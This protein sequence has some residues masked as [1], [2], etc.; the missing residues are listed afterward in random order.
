MKYQFLAALLFI[1]ELPALGQTTTGARLDFQFSRIVLTNGDTLTGP[2]AMRYKTDVLYLAQPDGTVRNLYPSMVAAFA[3]QGERFATGQGRY[4]ATP[5]ADPTVLRLFRTLPWSAEHPW[6]RPEPYFFEQLVEGPVLL[7]RR[8]LLVPRQ[9]A[10]VKPE[11]V[12]SGGPN[13]GQ[14][15]AS[16]KLPIM[17]IV[18][19]QFRTLNELQ[20]VFYLA[21][22]TGE[23]RSLHNPKKDLLAAF[24]EQAQ[25]LQ[26]YARAQGLGFTEAHELSS[27]VTY[28]NSLI[29]STTP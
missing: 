2:V 10:V 12:R 9:R 26:I 7:L 28:A 29:S 6:Q 18:P 8:Q 1:T 20:D 24:P 15:A 14:P 13:R 27:L 22:P 19:P 16:G 21:W 3:V 11:A 5:L 25:R 17:D 23:I 4:R